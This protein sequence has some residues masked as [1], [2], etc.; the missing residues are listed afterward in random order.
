MTLV[1]FEENTQ[2][3]S[4]GAYA[5]AGCRSLTSITIPESVTSIGADAF[6][7]C[8][9]LTSVTINA[10]TPPTLGSRAMPSN[11]RNIYVP[12]ESVSAYQ[13]ASGWSSYASKISA[14]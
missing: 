2:L 10:V 13:S 12:T 4:I 8:S 3:A 9:S 7:S 11:V 6:W 1:D 14:I 5:F